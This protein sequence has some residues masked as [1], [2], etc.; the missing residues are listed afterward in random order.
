MLKLRL[1]DFNIAKKRQ[2]IWNE[3]F[4]GKQNF[5]MVTTS[6]QTHAVLHLPYLHIA[7]RDA[8]RNQ[9]LI[10]HYGFIVSKE[11]VMLRRWER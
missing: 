5:S 9:V 8:V 3:T 4:K 1:I 10:L 6:F 11:T 7:L 2:I